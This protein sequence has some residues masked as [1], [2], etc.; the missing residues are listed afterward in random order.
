MYRTFGILLSI[1]LDQGLN[2]LAYLFFI[3]S[4]SQE[5]PL[6]FVERDKNGLV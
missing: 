6:S 2:I 5:R 3:S 1:L 4:F